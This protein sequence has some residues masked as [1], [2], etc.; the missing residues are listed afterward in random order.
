V[1]GWSGGV[2]K[3]GVKVHTDY[4]ELD[5]HTTHHT[6]HTN[7]P[8]TNTPYHNP[9]TH[10][11]TPLT[12]TRHTPIYHT[13]HAQTHHMIETD[14]PHHA[15]RKHDTQTPHANAT[16][17]THLDHAELDAKVGAVHAQLAGAVGRERVAGGHH[18]QADLP[19][20]VD[21][22]TPARIRAF[23]QSSLTSAQRAHTHA[24]P[25][26]SLL[27]TRRCTPGR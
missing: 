2:G 27:R 25:C 19:R 8:H 6:P 17:H 14:T 3:G 4:A 9:H 20:R 26:C 11:D 21:V 16:H 12:Q 23:T 18:G 22:I 13:Y 24:I 7:T 1:V 10:T 15:T 5:A